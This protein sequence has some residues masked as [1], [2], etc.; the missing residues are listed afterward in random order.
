MEVR[1]LSGAPNMTETIIPSA[2]MLLSDWITENFP[3]WKSQYE[4]YTEL[5]DKI[6]ITLP[7]ISNEKHTLELLRTLTMTVPRYSVFDVDG[8]SI[9]NPKF[10]ETF[11]EH[12]DKQAARFIPSVEQWK[13]DGTLPDR[14]N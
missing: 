5:E 11:K 13:K 9:C 3:D 2:A 10:F 1:V 7:L 8:V 14:I 4:S 12:M 6:I